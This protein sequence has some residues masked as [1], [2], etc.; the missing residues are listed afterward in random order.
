[1]RRNSSVSA[2]KPALKVLVCMLLL[3]RA[4]FSETRD[5][6][7]EPTRTTL[8]ALESCLGSEKSDIKD[9]RKG[10]LNGWG[11]G[12]GWHAKP[13]TAPPLGYSASLDLDL[14]Y[15]TAAS[16]SKDPRVRQQALAAVV[17]DIKLKSN[18]CHK[19]GMS[20]MVTVSV[21]TIEGSM[22]QNGW[23]VYYKWS[24]ASPFQTEEIRAPQL[25]SP[26]L[27]TLPPG[28]YTVRAQKA[29]STTQVQSTSPIPITVGS[30]KTV[31][32]QIP[33]P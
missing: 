15:C 29:L 16:E 22:T 7:L 10:L 21:S 8:A 6:A 26:S 32:V 13:P 11:G 17:K 28:D 30:E 27:I 4:G 25:T 31:M 20:R 33:I 19:F 18:D 9:L 2:L 1:M 24:P 3:C 12:W 14:K 23:E 5:A